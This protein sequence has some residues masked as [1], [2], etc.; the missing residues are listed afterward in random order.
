MNLKAPLDFTNNSKRFTYEAV[1]SI[2]ATT[3]IHFLFRTEPMLLLL[4]AIIFISNR[5]LVL[6]AGH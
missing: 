4:Q 1:N 3:H 5:V 6:L 2:T